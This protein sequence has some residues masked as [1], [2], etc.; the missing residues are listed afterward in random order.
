MF[1][2]RA[3]EKGF[4]G[5]VAQSRPASVG[6]S[7]LVPPR[8]AHLFGRPSSELGNQ[9]P[10]NRTPATGYVVSRPGPHGS[11][12]MHFVFPQTPTTAH[13]HDRSRSPSPTAPTNPQ[14][15]TENSSIKLYSNSP[16]SAR[17]QTPVGMVGNSSINSFIPDSRN[18]DGDSH[19]EVKKAHEHGRGTLGLR[20]VSNV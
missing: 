13:R 5:G 19:C 15:G 14:T 2:L 18:P 6:S 3:L 8:P 1:G 7:T 9:R 11:A 10:I 17:D 12:D 16:L 20:S 4:F